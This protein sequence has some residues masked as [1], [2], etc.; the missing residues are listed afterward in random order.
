M[1]VEFKMYLDV[2]YKSYNT[3]FYL[4]K[5]FVYVKRSNMQI[6]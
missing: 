6:C 1:K 3:Y 4:C 5:V 2:N